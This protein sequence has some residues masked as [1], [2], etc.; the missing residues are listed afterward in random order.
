MPPISINGML[1]TAIVNNI[2]GLREQ[3]EA[4]GEEATTGFQSDLVKH[5][6]GRIDQALLG[7]R[8]I[9]DNQDEQSRLGLRSIRLSLTDSTLTSVRELTAGLQIGMLGAIGTG[10]IES[11]DLFAT[12]AR[13]A[14]DDMLSRMNAR[15]GERFLFSGDAT[16]T[17][18]FGTADDLLNDIRAIAFAAT[19]EADF[20][21]QV[22]TYFDDPAGGFQTNF[23][24]GAQTASDAD[25][26]VGNQSAFSDMF[27][28]LAIMA[29]SRTSE[30][31]P[32]VGA[33]TP[34]MDTALERLERGR[35]ELVHIQANVGM[36][37]ANLAP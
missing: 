35:T 2:G 32:F 3:L 21:A 6:N 12:E 10:E 1:N 37:Q 11:Q 23:Y 9:Q 22:D 16:A 24:R 25:S 26:V 7:E 27:R 15:N 31:V 33:G 14:L 36:R 17:S 20:A 28:G 30:G 18:P 8:A 4:R 29:L 5:L 19:D 13:T 34:A